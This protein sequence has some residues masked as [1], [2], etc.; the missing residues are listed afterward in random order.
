MYIVYNIDFIR[1]TNDGK[2]RV[3]GNWTKE[4]EIEIDR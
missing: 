1:G 4:I 2:F 3:R